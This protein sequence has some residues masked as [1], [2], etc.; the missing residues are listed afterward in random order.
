MANVQ[1][2]MGRVLRYTIG[3]TS[4]GPWR[5]HRGLHG[6]QLP[7]LPRASIYEASERDFRVVAVADAISRF[8]ERSR[9][10]LEAIGVVVET[11]DSLCL[12]GG[13]T[14]ACS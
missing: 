2:M 12:R 11:V 13:P 10:E 1:A 5:Y 14:R 7:Q 8:D 3:E 6:L 9:S 4:A